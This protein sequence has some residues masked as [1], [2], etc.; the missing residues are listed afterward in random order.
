MKFAH[1]VKTLGVVGA[2]AMTLQASTSQADAQ[3]YANYDNP[4]LSVPAY[5][6]MH[7]RGSFRQQA[8]AF[9]QRLDAQ[10]QR[11]LHGMETGLLT[12]RETAALLNEHVAINALERQYLADGRFGPFELRDLEARLDRASK[13]IFFE[14]QDGDHRGGADR[15]GHNDHRHG[16]VPYRR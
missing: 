10:L 2:T 7:H 6:P 8:Q 14:K 5:Q 1:I 9:D 11:I 13:H 3:L 12:M 4:W 15:L 16:D